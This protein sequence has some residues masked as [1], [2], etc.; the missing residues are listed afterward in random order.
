MTSGRKVGHFPKALVSF[1]YTYLVQT[2]FSA[3][4][5]FLV[6]LFGLPAMSSCQLNQFSSW[7]RQ[8]VLARDRA[9]TIT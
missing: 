3:I 2:N 1:D 5:V 4:Q 9:V 8:V 7:S 6:F